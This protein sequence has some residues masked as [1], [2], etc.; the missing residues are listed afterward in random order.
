MPGRL[1]RPGPRQP[2]PPRPSLG[3]RTRLRPAPAPLFLPGGRALKLER[4]G[5]L[6][7]AVVDLEQDHVGAGSGSEGA[8]PAA[9][10]GDPPE[11]APPLPLSRPRVTS[12]PAP[13]QA[14]P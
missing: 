3:P 12:G 10:T 1:A 14:R 5:L 11:P 8:E 9:R 13:P 6:D 4:E 2:P 7:D